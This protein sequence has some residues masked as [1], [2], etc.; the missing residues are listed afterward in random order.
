M[1]LDELHRNYIAGEWV[2]GDAQPDVNP[3]NTDDIVGYYARA[4]AGDAEKAIAAAKAAFPS[5]SRSGIQ[6]RHDILKAASDE[7]LNRRQEIGR[8]LS[9][10]EGKPLA[11][12][13]AETVRAGQIF[14]FFAGECLRLAGETVPSVRPGIEVTMT[15]EPVGVVGII[16]PWNF[17][18]AIPAWKIAP[19]LCLRQHGRLQAGRPGAGLLVDDRRHSRARRT[20]QGRPQ[21]RHGAG[22]RRRRGD[23][24]FARCQRHHLHRF[25]PDRP[26]GRR[27]SRRSTCASSSSRWAARTRSSSSTTPTSRPP[28]SAPPMA[29]ISRPASAARPPRAWS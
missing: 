3:S 22:L 26:D 2:E 7:I 24:G 21:P 12:G 27:A 5:W 10:E 1:A 19:A 16:T 8:L 4:S 15:R 20:A 29:A 25:G 9:R 28:S 14:D 17:P 13:I 11:D 23:A 6:Q 18:I